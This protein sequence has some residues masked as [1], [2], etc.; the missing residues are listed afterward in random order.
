MKKHLAWILLILGFWGCTTFSQ[1]YIRGNKAEFGKQYDQ[2]IQEYEKAVIEN[3]REEVYRLALIRVKTSASM[4][5]WKAARA[6]MQQGKTEEAQA[7][8]AKALSYEPSNRVLADEAEAMM[9]K[10][11]AE[12]KLEAEAM[13]LPVK[14]R[15]PEEK[16]QL[17]FTQASIRSI[18]Q[19]L[20]KHAGVNFVYDEQFRDTPLSIDLVDRDFEQAVNFL[21]LA[22][23][24]FF[25]VIDEKTVVIVPDQPM[26]RLQYELNAIKTFYLSNINAQEIQQS[27]A[28]MLRTQYKAPN[29]IID[30]N[31]NSI[32]VRDTPLSVSLAGK[33]LRNWDKAKGEVVI[34]LEIMEVSRNKL[35]K[36]GIDW[37]T[38]AAS[39]RYSGAEGYPEDGWFSLKGMDLGQTANYQISLPS[40]YLQL[41][42]SDSDTKMIAQ[43]RLRGVGTEEIKYM[44]GQKVPIPQTTF[45]PIA[46]GG[47]STQPITSYTYQDVGID[48]KIKPRI[49][50]EKEITLELEIKLTSLGGTGYADIPIITTREVKNVIRLK[51][52]ETN[53]LAGLLKDEERKSLKGIAGIK[54]I[55][56]LGSLF[57]NTDQTIEQ[58]DVILTITPYIIRSLPLSEEDRKPLW[59]DVESLSGLGQ[60]S[61]R[62]MIPEAMGATGREEPGLERPE[63]PPEPP[64][65]PE[66]S[67]GRDSITIGPSDF[68]VPKGR[69]FGMTLNIRNENEIG[70]LSV[71]VSYDPRIIKLDAVNPG[72][73]VQELGDKTPFLSNIDN[74]GGSCTIGVSVPG[75]TRGVKGA[76][77]LAGLLFE[78][79]ADG[80]A[81]VTIVN[82]S[83]NAPNGRA[84]SFETNQARVIIR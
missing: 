10:P 52:G 43:P 6:L 72:S 15:V 51:D 26:K 38:A 9:K 66:E 67:R 56:I 30:K 78:G 28:M 13:E 21:C 41:L 32:T 22:S 65:E 69:Q 42:E 63:N 77:S 70:N 11:V 8:Y 54:R 82:A 57:S 64:E 59:V 3:P 83:A 5:H 12:E 40:A 20:G 49:H 18:F 37:G 39:M 61:E 74:A 27:L 81:V 68:E 17:K 34:D 84:V 79:I 36:L 75:G 58:T 47:I 29:L 14:L 73:F 62:M 48:I 7:E 24:N 55:P 76:G 60:A 50:T 31:L 53:L 33:L 16:V 80:E 4:H 71:T 45:S 1:Y 35:L 19:A 25:R 2:A 46:A 23:K 44:V